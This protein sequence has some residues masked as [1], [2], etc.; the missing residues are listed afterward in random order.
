ML[1][2]CV[3]STLGYFILCKQANGGFIK[4]LWFV[5]SRM[6]MWASFPDVLNLIF[7]VFNFA[8]GHRLDGTS[9][10]LKLLSMIPVAAVAWLVSSTA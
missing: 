5:F 7:T 2:I 3:V 10:M 9:S 4:F 6:S 8:N 1:I